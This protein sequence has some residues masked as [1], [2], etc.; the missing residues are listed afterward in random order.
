MLPPPLPEKP[1]DA[2][3]I[4]LLVVLHYVLAALSLA[5]LGLLLLHFYLMSSVFGM[6]KTAKHD[7]GERVEQVQEE[8]QDEQG[9]EPPGIDA[10]R[11]H[12]EE[13]VPDPEETEVEVR[14]MSAEELKAM[15]KAMS[16]FSGVFVVFYVLM[17]M[18][19]VLV[20]VLNF[21]SARAMTG[22]KNKV[23]SMVTAG[24][25]CLGFPLGTALGVFTFVVLGRPS[26]SAMYEKRLS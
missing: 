19:I 9:A 16:V 13:L 24:V 4:Q 8:A 15:K 11:H 6:M 22:R 20:A 1:Q 5:G 12:G 3:Q 7:F 18:F 26:V 14:Q 21:L 2:D 17:G 25:N 23:L 10:S